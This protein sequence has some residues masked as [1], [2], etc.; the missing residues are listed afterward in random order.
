M[1]EFELI[2]HD[3]NTCYNIDHLREQISVV[4]AGVAHICSMTQTY[5]ESKI[6]LYSNSC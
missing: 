1:Y 6:Y 5:D 2:F 3:F 4:C